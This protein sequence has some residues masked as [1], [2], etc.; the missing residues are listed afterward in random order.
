MAVTE[1]IAA[2]GEGF[3][4]NLRH[5]REILGRL[6]RLEGLVC[7]DIRMRLDRHMAG[8]LHLVRSDMKPR[9]IIRLLRRN[10]AAAQGTVDAPRA[11]AID[12]PGAIHAAGLR[13]VRAPRNGT[14]DALRAVNAIRCRVFS[15]LRAVH[16][17]GTVYRPTGIFM[18]IMVGQRGRLLLHPI[19]NLL[20]SYRKSSEKSS[21]S[22]LTFSTEG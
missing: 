2:L 13:A 16:A 17:A 10:T 9:E 19:F 4:E 20:L 6:Y 8:Q 21:Y 12:I 18:F 11:A 15:A 22:F 1:E 7:G 14:V 5:I 3:A